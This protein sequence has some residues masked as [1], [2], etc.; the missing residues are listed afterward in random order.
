MKLL[1][2]RDTV[3][4]KD[5]V[6]VHFIRH[7]QAHH[8]VHNKFNSSPDRISHY[9]KR[10]FYDAKLT[11][12]GL[13]QALCINVDVDLIIVSP[14]SRALETAIPLAKKNNCSVHISDNA[15]EA[16]VLNNFPC[17]RRKKL[18]DVFDYL[19][20]CEIEVI[21]HLEL[22]TDNEDPFADQNKV[23]SSEELDKQL[24]DLML[25]IKQLGIFYKNIAVISH[26]ITISSIMNKYSMDKYSY[27]KNCEVLSTILTY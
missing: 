23:Q 22:Q 17:N 11:P 9:L 19:S 18:E 2:L 16:N 4:T 3:L 8:N 24:H 25:E 15:R 1:R 21:N 7:G 13:T 20:D 12:L 6:V 10:D 5:S 14:L 27:I 26:S